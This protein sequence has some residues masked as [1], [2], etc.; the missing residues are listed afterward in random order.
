MKCAKLDLL[1]TM[2]EGD[3][4]KKLTAY[5]QQTRKQAESAIDLLN[6]KISEMQ[7]ENGTCMEMIS[8]LEK[9]RDYYKDNYEQVKIENS[10]KWKLRERD[11]WK[12]LVENVQHD[13]DRLQ[14]ICVSLEAELEQSQINSS[15]LGNDNERLLSE[16]ER[17]QS[18]LASLEN[19]Q[20]SNTEDATTGSS[21]E[22]SNS[23]I[24][25]EVFNST[26]KASLRKPKPIFHINTDEG[27]PSS[28]IQDRSGKEINFNGFTPNSINKQLK[29]ELRKAQM[30]MDYERRKA[31]SKLKLYN[32]EIERL[33][34]KLSNV[35]GGAGKGNGVVPLSQSSYS[36]PV[37]STTWFS[38]VGLI[39]YLFNVNSVSTSAK[40]HDLIQI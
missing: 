25:S 27:E 37:V 29:M 4:L 17:L 36:K 19:A 14:D 23:S 34:S 38:P 31:E 8:K 26:Q 21:I 3:G 28:P 11:E 18:S 13:R 1:K 39:G 9:E 20:S 22:D 35:M 32:N 6:E 30:E 12:S 5:L 10:T 33:S 7:E 2:S 40:R 16:N 15:T 24:N